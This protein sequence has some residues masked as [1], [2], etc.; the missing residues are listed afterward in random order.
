MRLIL[1]AAAVLL[2]A[3]SPALGQTPPG[4]E[5]APAVSPTCTGF[6]APPSLPDGANANASAMTRGNESYTEWHTATEAK[7]QQCQT[8]IAAL[9]TQLEAMV[10]S[11]NQAEQRRFATQ[12]AWQGEVEEFNGR[13]GA[14]RRERGGVLT[15]PDN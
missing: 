9:R 11:Y 12:T 7:K 13:S 10:E 5:T 15:R 14:N 6:V 3:G 4:P 1:G 8:E 2:L